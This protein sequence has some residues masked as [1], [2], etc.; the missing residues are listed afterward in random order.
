MGKSEVDLEDD[1]DEINE[2]AEVIAAAAKRLEDQGRSS[3]RLTASGQR[4]KEMENGDGDAQLSDNASG[5]GEL[6]NSALELE[7]LEGKENGALKTRRSRTYRPG[8]KSKHRT[9][10]ADR[11]LSVEDDPWVTD[12]VKVRH[13]KKRR[14][15]ELSL[16]RELD[17]DSPYQKKD[18]V[19]EALDYIFGKYE[20]R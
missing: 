10:S 2:H 4:K 11:Q 9:P 12:S 5:D 15:K 1:I 20:Q 8:K 14:L 19:D 3:T 7:V 6:A 13:S 17:R 16:R 18:L